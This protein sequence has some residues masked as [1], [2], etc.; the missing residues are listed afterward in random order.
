[1]GAVAGFLPRVRIAPV[2]SAGGRG[3][4]AAMR[5]VSGVV[6]AAF[7]GAVVGAFDVRGVADSEFRVGF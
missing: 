1:M 2:V 5:A 6:R 7:A 4:A 3:V